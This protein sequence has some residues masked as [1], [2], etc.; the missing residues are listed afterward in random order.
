MTTSNPTPS[1][2]FSSRGFVAAAIVIGVIVLA[3]VIVA[4]TALTAPKGEPPAVASAPSSAPAPSG[5]ESICG[6]KGHEEVSSL[7]DA[8]DVEWELVGTVAAP[9]DPGGAGPG[10]IEDNDFRYCYAHTAEGA[11]F[12]AVGWFAATSD[13]RNGPRIPELLAAEV[14]DDARLQL[15]QS[16]TD[17]AQVAGFKVISYTTDEAVID[18]AYAITTAQGQ[19]VN[20]PAVLRWEDGDWKVFLDEDTLERAGPLRSLGGYIP[21]AGV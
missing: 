15:T 11:L 20:V 8:P 21:W 7:T 5:D 6:L 12:A 16:T 19:L 4:V 18:I 3:G 17:R 2:P 13:V 10:V 9:T 1:G 14:R